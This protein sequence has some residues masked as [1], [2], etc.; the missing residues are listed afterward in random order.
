MNQVG[1]VAFVF[2][3]VPEKKKRRPRRFRG[4]AGFLSILPPLVLDTLRE[5][6]D[7]MTAKQIAE[8]A[9]THQGTVW[10]ALSNLQGERKVIKRKTWGQHVEYRALRDGEV[11]VG[12]DGPQTPIY[13]TDLDARPLSEALFGGDTFA[14]RWAGFAQELLSKPKASDYHQRRETWQR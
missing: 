3:K 5:N 11:H 10:K 7:W 9:D 2:A 14:D 6:G 4:A 12:I 1:N 8:I 13:Y